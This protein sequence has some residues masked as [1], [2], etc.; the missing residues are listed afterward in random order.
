MNGWFF[1]EKCWGSPPPEGG[2]TRRST[3]GPRRS[4]KGMPKLQRRWRSVNPKVLQRWWSIEELVEVRRQKMVP[5]IAGMLQAA[6]RRKMM[7]VKSL[8]AC[9]RSSLRVVEHHGTRRFRGPFEATLSKVMTRTFGCGGRLKSGERW[10]RRHT[11]LV[12]DRYRRFPKGKKT[13]DL[14]RSIQVRLSNL[15][16]LPNTPIVTSWPSWGPEGHSWKDVIRLGV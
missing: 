15:G 6:R 8:E 9:R 12:K 5:W 16:K 3:E 13:R 14:G 4:P 11:K 7:K 10:R 1:L 2:V